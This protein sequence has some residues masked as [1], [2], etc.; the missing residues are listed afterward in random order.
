MAEKKSKVPM[1]SS[2]T[3]EGR[4]IPVEE[5]MGIL[6]KILGQGPPS[7][8][9]REYMQKVSPVAEDRFIKNKEGQHLPLYELDEAALRAI[10]ADPGFYGAYSPSNDA[11]MINPI[12][13]KRS[14]KSLEELD[15][16]RKTAGHEAFH[17]VQ[18][19]NPG[20]SESLH[21]SVVGANRGDIGRKQYINF[22]DLYSYIDPTNASFGKKLPRSVI[23]AQAHILSGTAPSIYEDY[24][25]KWAGKPLV[26][27]IRGPGVRRVFPYQA[28]TRV[29]DPN[30]IAASQ[31]LLY[32]QIPLEAQ[33]RLQHLQLP[34]ELEGVRIEP[35]KP[36]APAAPFTISD[37]YN[38]FMSIL[39]LGPK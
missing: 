16:F 25:Q 5:L 29:A 1:S 9:T 10:N 32:P 38:K 26:G 31:R 13:S 19:Y 12:G 35:E 24:G 30:S 17:A 36:A 34:V 37:A 27:F 14:G 23:E 18:K 15:E 7:G 3:R 6:A 20:L 2:Y 11:V 33:R 22:H 28:S 39:G 21:E 4:Q 8:A